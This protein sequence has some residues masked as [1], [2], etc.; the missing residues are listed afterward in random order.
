MARYYVLNHSR[1]K[2]RVRAAQ[3]A[4]LILALYTVLMV[5]SFCRA[6]ERELIGSFDDDAYYYFKIAQ[7]FAH[8]GQLTFDGQT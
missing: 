1:S 7:N 4:V 2:L 5:V 6:G 3:V 8:T